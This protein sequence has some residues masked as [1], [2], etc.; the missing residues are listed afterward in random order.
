M[1]YLPDDVW[2]RL[3]IVGWRLC[4]DDV[5]H[6]KHNTT[7]SSNTVIG[8][9]CDVQRHTDQQRWRNGPGSECSE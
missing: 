4:I 9:V 7:Q 5:Q 2:W 3:E 6:D 1:K 8:P